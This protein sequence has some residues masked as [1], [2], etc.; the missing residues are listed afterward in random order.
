MNTKSCL[1]PIFARA[2][3]HTV[4]RR[5]FSILEAM[6]AV[7][8]LSV[9]AT[10]TLSTVAPMRARAEQRIREAQLATLNNLVQTF[11][12]E[13][14][15]F[16]ED[17]VRTLASRGYLANAD[18]DAKLHNE[19]LVRDYFYDRNTGTFTQR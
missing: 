11:F 10:A 1:E 18:E 19:R 12:L 7:T 5:G 8:I 14:G 9:I 4:R 15:R 17:G 6:A 2:M 13:T 3:E 16:P